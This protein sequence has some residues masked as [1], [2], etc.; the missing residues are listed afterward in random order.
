[1]PVRKRGRPP[2]SLNRST[3]ARLSQSQD[4]TSSQGTNLSLRQTRSQSVRLGAGR[5]SGVR[6]SGQRLRSSVRRERS[7]WELI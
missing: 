3:I 6:S 5:N 1:L 7:G 4:V 2:G